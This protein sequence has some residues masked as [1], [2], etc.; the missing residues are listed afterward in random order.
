[1]DLAS[2]LLWM[3]A[4]TQV[5]RRR[6]WLDSVTSDQVILATIRARHPL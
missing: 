6:R 3:L 5:R 1:L 2:S 4:I